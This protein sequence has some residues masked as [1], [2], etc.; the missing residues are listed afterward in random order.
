MPDRDIIELLRGIIGSGYEGT[1]S[2][3]CNYLSDEGYQLTQ[4][5]VSRTLK[6]IGAVKVSSKSG[7]RYEL[8]VKNSSPVG[9]R[10]AM[11]EL[12][13][14]LRSNESQIVIRTRP[15]SAMFVAGFIDHH[16]SAT[17]L[18]TIAGDDTIFIAPRSVKDILSCERDV[19]GYL[20]LD[21]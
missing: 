12:V 2:D 17:I 15:G 18:G 14:S 6:K 11:K 1:Q 20:N 10:G 4:S 21:G 16:C 13:I 9:F 8:Q 19:K 5:T 7:S 3:L